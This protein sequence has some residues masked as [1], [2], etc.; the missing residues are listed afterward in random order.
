METWGTQKQ[1]YIDDFQMNATII[2]NFNVVGEDTYTGF[3]H[4]GMWYDYITGDSIDVSNVNMTIYLNPGEWRIFT[5]QLLEKP[6]M[7]NPIDTS[8]VLSTKTNTFFLEKIYIFG[9]E[10]KFI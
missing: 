8:S 10:I 1:I 6:D 2:G 7:T 9:I 4:T 3:Q 5:D